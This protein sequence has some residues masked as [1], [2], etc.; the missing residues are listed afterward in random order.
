MR[1]LPAQERQSSL[2][3]LARTALENGL[4]AAKQQDWATAVKFFQEAQHQAPLTPEVLFDL[5]LAESKISG[6]E[7][8]AMAWFEAY[9]ALN[10]NAANR[11]QVERELANL[12]SHVDEAV[13]KIIQTAQSMAM[14]LSPKDGKDKLLYDVAHMRVLSG[15]VSGA[16]LVAGLIADN[17]YQSKV[18]ADVANAE[19]GTLTEKEARSTFFVPAYLAI[20]AEQGRRG[21][22]A[23]A[24]QSE[25]VALKTAAASSYPLDRA[26][27]YVEIAEEQAKR[28]D[29]FAAESS[30][31]QVYNAVALIDASREGDRDD[32]Y[33]RL[34]SELAGRGNFAMASQTTTMI[35]SESKISHVL[36]EIARDLAHRGNF[37]EARKAAKMANEEESDACVII[38]EE[39]ATHGDLAA[40]RHTLADALAV[41]RGGSGKRSWVSWMILAR[42][43]AELGNAPGAKEAADHAAIFEFLRPKLYSMIAERQFERGDMAGAKQT[44]TEA[45]RAA[46]AIVDSD[47]RSSAYARI[48]QEQARRG[49]VAGAKQSEADA[50]RAAA[51]IA[52][53]K[54]KSR[55][56]ISIAEAQ[57]RHGDMAEARRSTIEALKTVEG[58]SG[59]PETTEFWV[60]EQ[61]AKSIASDPDVDLALREL[62]AMRL[63]LLEMTPLQEPLYVTPLS[64]YIH[65]GRDAGI[66][67]VL[68]LITAKEL[69]TTQQEIRSIAAN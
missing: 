52:D 58:G 26:L 49:D 63:L 13:E 42:V 7:L 25:A 2:P 10:P 22:A 66:T 48:A 47:G 28:G 5:G 27:M 50:L 6:R 36:A 16:R 57:A 11:P 30:E 24:R 33:V 4:A 64:Q 46:A 69:T 40:A 32:V 29:L 14:E 53:T 43:Q 59:S 35:K 62:R 1:E 17:A 39:Q 3:P 41:T 34:A 45:L 67:I 18:Y 31:V 55:A 44:E 9:L 60:W 23:G 37:S 54:E 20:A 65:T 56:Y 19:K 15:N 21:D 51:A 61:I 12:K 38:A 68:L 8:R